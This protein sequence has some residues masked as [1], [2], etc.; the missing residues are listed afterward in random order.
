MGL[1]KMNPLKRSI[2]NRLSE[3]GNKRWLQ[4]LHAANDKNGL[5]EAALLINTLYHQERVKTSWLAREA[6]GRLRTSGTAP[7]IERGT[8]GPAGSGNP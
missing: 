1:L 7:H 8:D 4:Q 6:C 3:E 5:L 2:E